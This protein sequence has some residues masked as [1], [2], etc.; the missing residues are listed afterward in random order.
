MDAE[1]GGLF[2]SAA[3]ASACSRRRPLQVASSPDPTPSRAGVPVHE[4]SAAAHLGLRTWRSAPGGPS[5]FYAEVK[6]YRLTAGMP[7]APPDEH[8]A[9]HRAFAQACTRSGLRALHFGVLDGNLAGGGK[10]APVTAR[11]H[12]PSCW[13]LGDL[14]VF[15]LARWRDE[16]LLPASLRAQVRRARRQGVTIRHWAAPPDA[17][18]RGAL[19]A[20]RDAWMRAKPL[21]PLAFMTTPYLF[22]PWPRDGVFIAEAHGR[23]VGFLV[24]SRAL[25]GDMLRVDAVARV[26]GAPNGTAELLVREAFRW[27]AHR[28]IEHATLGLAPLSRRSG[29]R[30]RGWRRVVFGGVRRAGAPLYSFGGLETFKARFAPDAWLPLYAVA[31]GRTFGPRDLC[32]IARAFAG[33]SL[34][35]FVVR[36]LRRFGHHVAVPE[37]AGQLPPG[38]RNGLVAR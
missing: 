22:E 18:S 7:C 36:A 28:G 16:T 2:V 12:D 14:P 9:L 33:G 5:V 17:A 3:P 26:P 30:M 23:I 34:R 37:I 25:F 13:H 35:R 15:G 19:R 1:R 11:A 20:V 4:A 31:P 38:V 29:V 24:A 21:P 8:G 32:A 6:G 27:A 10:G